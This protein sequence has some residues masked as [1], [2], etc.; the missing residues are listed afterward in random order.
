MPSSEGCFSMVEGRLSVLCI[1]FGF[2]AVGAVS[3]QSMPSIIKSMSS[4]AA[5]VAASSA[6][7]ARVPIPRGAGK[8]A[9]DV[10]AAPAKACA[11]AAAAR[12]APL[13]ELFVLT[14]AAGGAGMARG[15]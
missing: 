5:P 3:T 9:P 7:P 12:G 4:S 11:Q 2:R 8:P 1:V 6:P 13:A 15:V 14:P 10:V